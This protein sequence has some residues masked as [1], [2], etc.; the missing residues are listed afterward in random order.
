MA[1]TIQPFSGYSDEVGE[2]A[3]SVPEGD[4]NNA[5]MA[6]YITEMLESKKDETPRVVKIWFFLWRLCDIDT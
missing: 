3:L 5:H 2:S 4:A 6:Q 1:S